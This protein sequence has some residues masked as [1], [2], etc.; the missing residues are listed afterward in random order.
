MAKGDSSCYCKHEMLLQGH[1]SSHV[2]LFARIVNKR[3]QLRKDFYTNK[4][5]SHECLHG[6][7]SYDSLATK[8]EEQRCEKGAKGI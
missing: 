1:R 4:T 3:R 8:P 5:L 7:D 2:I 6:H